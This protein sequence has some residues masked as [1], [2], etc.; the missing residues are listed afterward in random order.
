MAKTAAERQAAYRARRK[1]GDGDNR[2]N[3]WISSSSYRAL[4]RLAIHCNFTKK[5]L[6]ERLIISAD[7]VVLKTLPEQSPERDTYLN[8]GKK[9][10]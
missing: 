5:E 7:S 3:T 8:G 9:D 1:E 2:L 10:V 6:L 4:E